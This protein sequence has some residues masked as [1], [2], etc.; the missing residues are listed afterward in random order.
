[1]S[2]LLNRSPAKPTSHTSAST[3]D[4]PARMPRLYDARLF[5]AARRAS[6]HALSP[7][8]IVH[9]SPSKYL[10]LTGAPRI[11]RRKVS[12]H[13]SAKRLP[14]IALEE[15]DSSQSASSVTGTERIYVSAVWAAGCGSLGL[16]TPRFVSFSIPSAT[17][18][19]GLPSRGTHRPRKKHSNETPCLDCTR[20]RD[21]YKRLRICFAFLLFSRLTFL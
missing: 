20:Y 2:I 4:F 9:A 16:N 8:R 3:L 18:L 14:S 19:R 21:V 17:P 1:M 5:T 13:I 7:S 6:H 15:K 12:P 10:S 11:R